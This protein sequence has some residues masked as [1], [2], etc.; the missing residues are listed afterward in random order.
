MLTIIHESYEHIPIK[1]NTMLQMHRDLY[2]Y[3]GEINSGSFK[4]VDNEIIETDKNG[5]VHLRFVPVKSWETKEHINEMCIAYAEVLKEDYFNP[6]LIIPMFILDF[7]CIHPFSDGNGRMSRLLTLLLLYKNDYTVGKYISIENLINKSKEE[8]YETL[9]ECSEGWHENENTYLPF[10]KYMLEII[11]SAY[12]EFYGRLSLIKESSFSK[13]DKIREVIKNK[14]GK[15][16]KAE[17]MEKCP[18][19]SHITVQRTLRELQEKGE[20]KKIGNGRY[21]SYVWG[22]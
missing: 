21:T 13:P 5:N 15:I 11:V 2:K 18:D 1:D 14:L 17:I 10:V 20:I 9:K 22:D 6:L 3:S 12:R 4:N 19:V 7:L 8:Y 16:T